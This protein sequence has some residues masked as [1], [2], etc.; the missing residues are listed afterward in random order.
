MDCKRPASMMVGLALLCGC[1][2][3]PYSPVTK[4]I[5]TSIGT[6][7]AALATN[8]TDLKTARAAAGRYARRDMSR[9]PDTTVSPGC[10]Q[11]VSS[12]Q[13]CVQVVQEPRRAVHAPVPPAR[14]HMLTQLH[15]PAADAYECPIVPATNATPQTEKPS[16]KVVTVQLISAT[17][18]S[19][20]DA[21]GAITN[22]ADR[23]AL[24]LAVGDLSKSVGILTASGSSQRF[25]TP[26]ALLMTTSG[27][28]AGAMHRQH[29]GVTDELLAERPVD[30]AGEKGQLTRPMR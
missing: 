2:P 29:K 1:S 28:I 5:S 12:G 21:L 4:K 8:E 10:D 9:L 25:C 23:T 13:P 17:L 27:D 15:P 3:Y 18:K 11:P 14:P 7:S 19:Y 26:L 30:F 22:A 16:E 20:G 24:D 6:I